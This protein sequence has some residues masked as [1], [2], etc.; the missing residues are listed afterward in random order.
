M[1]EGTDSVLNNESV[2]SKCSY[3]SFKTLPMHGRKNLDFQFQVI[4]KVEFFLFLRCQ[5]KTRNAGSKKL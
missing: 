3:K 4:F 5:E 1:F 2:P